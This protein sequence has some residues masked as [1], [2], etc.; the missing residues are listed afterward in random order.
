MKKAQLLAL[1]LTLSFY[2]SITCAQDAIG[3]C[4][5]E[6]PFIS[7][8]EKSEL[9]MADFAINDKSETAFCFDS[10][11]QVNNKEL[12][13]D[14]TMLNDLGLFDKSGC[15]IEKN[16]N[17]DNEALVTRFLQ[18]SLEGKIQVY[19]I[20]PYGSKA[21]V[22]YTNSENEKFV[23]N[24]FT[25][26]EKWKIAGVSA[27]SIAIGALIS[28]KAYKGQADKRKHWM[29]GATISGLTTGT[30]YLLLETAGLGDKLN[31]S[32]KTKEKIILFS[33]PVM[34]TLVGILKEVYDTKHKN[35]H[36]PD[37]NDAIATSLG[38]GVSVFAINM[39]F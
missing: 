5:Q 14:F 35:K 32:K 11:A 19:A 18:K 20:N 30:T 39:A 15:L 34:G 3:D 23:N 2:S 12:I 29:V 25:T 16:R 37:K 9:P 8:R 6:Q 28:E 17:A 10:K 22:L 7:N 1:A 33:G 38:A 26:Q 36:T 21:H 24:A 4:G 13:E 31:L 27:A